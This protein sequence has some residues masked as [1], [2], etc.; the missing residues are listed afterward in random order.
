MNGLILGIISV[1]VGKREGGRK[2][3]RNWGRRRSI[4][5]VR[6]AGQKGRSVMLE[7]ALRPKIIR[8][9]NSESKK[10]E[11]LEWRSRK[12]SNCQ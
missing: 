10:G 8:S 5:W 9:N 2:R 7:I 12:K 11:N 4:G 6:K 1:K 3:G